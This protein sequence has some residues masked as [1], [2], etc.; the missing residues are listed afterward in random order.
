MKGNELKRLKRN[1]QQGKKRVKRQY[2]PEAK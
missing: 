1:D 2:V